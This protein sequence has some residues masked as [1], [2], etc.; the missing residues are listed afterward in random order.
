MKSILNNSFA[1]KKRIWIFKLFFDAYVRGWYRQFVDVLTFA[2]TST[3]MKM[4]I[5]IMHLTSRGTKATQFMFASD[6]ESRLHDMTELVANEFHSPKNV[7]RFHI[8]HQVM[9]C[10]DESRERKFSLHKIGFHDIFGD[11]KLFI[12]GHISSQKQWNLFEN[13]S[14][15]AVWIWIAL[16][17]HETASEITT[18]FIANADFRLGQR[19]RMVEET[20]CG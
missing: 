14:R 16:R 1:T 2:L 15:F 5:S 20:E 19:Q 10:D 11:Y 18:H 3:R 9:R 17:T 6:D 12:R 8:Q 7:Q 4:A 13:W